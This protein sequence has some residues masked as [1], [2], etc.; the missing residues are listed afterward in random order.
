MIKLLKI[1]N[2]NHHKKAHYKNA[3]CI[4]NELLITN[5]EQLKAHLLDNRGEVYQYI[6]RVKPQALAEYEKIKGIK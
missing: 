5:A 1:E 3:L 6:K 4:H 2:N